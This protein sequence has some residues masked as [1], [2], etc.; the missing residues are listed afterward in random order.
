MT[1]EEKKKPMNSLFFFTEKRDGT[2]KARACANGSSQRHY[3]SKEKAASPKVSTESILITSVLDAK[4][5][6]MSSH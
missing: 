4:Q 6:G 3:I 2:I 5:K 1:K